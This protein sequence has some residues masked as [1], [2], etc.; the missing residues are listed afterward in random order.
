MTAFVVLIAEKH[1]IA[2]SSDGMITASEAFGAFIPFSELILCI[3]VAVFAFCT[4]V[5][6][7]YYGT[8][9]LAYLTKSKRARYAY[10][11]VY[12]LCAALGALAKSDTV[13]SFS[14]LAIS[15]MCAVNLVAVML[16]IREVK[17]ETDNYFGKNR[18]K[19]I[20][21]NIPFLN[22]TVAKRRKM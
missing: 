12:S 2:L 19:M 17:Q 18:C 22:N 4:I 20:N 5:C 11:I 6:W 13:W 1:G 7:F 21:N 9:S 3:S 8:E 10:L 15:A 16:S 14:D